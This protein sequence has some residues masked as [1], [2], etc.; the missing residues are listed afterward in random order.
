[1]ARFNSHIKNL[2]IVLVPALP[3]FEGGIKVG[4]KPGKYATF[5]GGRFETDDEEVIE[6]LEKLPTFGIDFWRVSDDAE[7]E[8]KQEGGIADFESM[9]KKELLL[10]AKEK[11]IEVEGNPTKEELIELLKGK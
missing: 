11:S 6:K 7:P 5:S 9:T 2:R 3:I 4:D 10:L 1:M 8:G